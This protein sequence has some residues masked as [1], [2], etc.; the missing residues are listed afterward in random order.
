MLVHCE[1]CLESAGALYM[2]STEFKHMY[3]YIYVHVASMYGGDVCMIYIVYIC[4]EEHNK[5]T[6]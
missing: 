4:I 6:E 2:M 3:V 5:E 1:M